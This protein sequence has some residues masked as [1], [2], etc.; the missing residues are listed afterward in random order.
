MKLVNYRKLIIRIS[1]ITQLKR[2][3]IFIWDFTNWTLVC[4]FVKNLSVSYIQFV[5]S[6]IAQMCAEKSLSINDNKTL[7]YF[8]LHPELSRW[9]NDVDTIQ[10][11]VLPHHCM[12]S[13]RKAGQMTIGKTRP[14]LSYRVL[15]RN[16]FLVWFYF[17]TL[18]VLMKPEIHGPEPNRT[19]TSKEW[20][21]GPN[22]TEPGPD[23]QNFENLGPI[24]IPECSVGCS[25][26]TI[27]LFKSDTE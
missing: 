22:R 3:I 7:N 20:S 8:V 19:R 25:V 2:H 5:I 4:L 11:L 27:R 24:R 13:M 18:I 15:N 10:S 26:K 16:L 1:P 6:Q 23:K 17:Q 12:V 21:L 9:V 14:R